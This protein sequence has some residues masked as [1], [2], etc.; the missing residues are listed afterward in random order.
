MDFS[1]RKRIV[2]SRI[3]CTDNSVDVRR[4]FRRMSAGLSAKYLIDHRISAGL[5]G[6]DCRWMSDGHLASFRQIQ[7]EGRDLGL[8]RDQDRTGQGS[9][10]ELGPG[11]DWDGTGKGSGRDWTGND[12]NSSS[13]QSL[14]FSCGFLSIA[15]DYVN[16]SRQLFNST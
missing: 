8:G 12:G 16:L 9:G 4:I 6:P 11:R 10:R 15:S 2:R 14:S 7:L 13:G 5:S 1:M 3:S